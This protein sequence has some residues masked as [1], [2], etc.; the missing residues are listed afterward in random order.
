MQTSIYYK[1]RGYPYLIQAQI[2]VWKV[3]EVL[4]EEKSFEGVLKKI[5]SL[6]T[7]ELIASMYYAGITTS[8]GQSYDM[9]VLG[10]S[11]RPVLG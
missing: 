11:S 1:F 9:A 6:T 5:P 8:I 4:L 2:P 7:E 3:I 10:I